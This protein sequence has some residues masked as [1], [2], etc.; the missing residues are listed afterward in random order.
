MSQ[1]RRVS[2]RVSAGLLKHLLEIPPDVEMVGLTWEP[3]YDGMIVYF[4]GAGLP[5]RCETAEGDC[6]KLLS[7][8]DVSELANGL[9]E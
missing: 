5:A 7:V 3:E 9:E 8:H 2:V 1:Q 4:A 6:G